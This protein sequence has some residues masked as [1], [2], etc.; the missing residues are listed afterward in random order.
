MLLVLKQALAMLQMQS[1][2]SSNLDHHLRSLLVSPLRLRS[3]SEAVLCCKPNNNVL[4]PMH[5][6][7]L[8]QVELHA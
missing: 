3:E 5:A 2:C 4:G 6:N 7:V 8:R 1:T